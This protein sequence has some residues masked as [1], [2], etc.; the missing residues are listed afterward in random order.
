VYRD[1]IQIFGRESFLLRKVNDWCTW[2]T[3]VLCH[4][5]PIV[6]ALPSMYRDSIQ[7]SRE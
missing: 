5:R 7:S 2:F 6:P 3:F 1:S 4:D